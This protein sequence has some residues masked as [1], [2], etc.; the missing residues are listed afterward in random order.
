MGSKLIAQHS[1][2]SKGSLVQDKRY[3][4]KLNRYCNWAAL[5]NEQ[6]RNVYKHLT[7]LNDEQFLDEILDYLKKMFN[8]DSCGH[9]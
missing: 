1:S 5:I 8:W 7:L 2:A 6:M 3:S 4:F 9:F